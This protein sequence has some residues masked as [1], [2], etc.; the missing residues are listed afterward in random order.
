MSSG[1][2]W[3]TISLL[4]RGR[5]LKHFPSHSIIK[6]NYHFILRLQQPMFSYSIKR[7]GVPVSDVRN[8]QQLTRRRRGEKNYFSPT[9]WFK[10][11][12]FSNWRVI[13]LSAASYQNSVIPKQCIK[14]DKCHFQFASIQ[15]TTKI[16]NIGSVCISPRLFLQ[17]INI[18]KYCLQCKVCEK[19]SN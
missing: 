12:N 17:A 18:W 5:S 3:N 7:R 9:P 8:I 19:K 13:S 1:C 4:S 10:Q 16:K 15:H 6:G 11:W 14:L 2:Q